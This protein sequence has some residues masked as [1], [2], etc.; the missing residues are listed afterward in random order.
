LEICNRLRSMQEPEKYLQFTQ[1]AVQLYPGEPRTLYHEALAQI[2][3]KHYDESARL[4]EQV[5]K[6]SETRAPELLDDTFHFEL[7]VSLERGGHFEEAALQFEKS[8]ELTPQDSPTK[9]AAAMN[10]LGYMWLERSEHL[11]KAEE[12]IKKANDLEPGNAAYMD[13]LGWVHFKTGRVG[14]ALGELLQAEQKLKQ[15]EPDDAEIFDHIAQAYDKSGQRAKA[16]EYWRRV[17]D[18]K[19]PDE[20][21]IQRAEKELGLKKPAPAAVEEPPA[22][23]KVR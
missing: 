20:K 22:S 6:L 7:G 8:I 14:E 2:Q 18:L 4:F 21:L 10:Y 1:R 15:P 12:L 11:D 16:E 3:N 19:P 23:S 13:S 5:A 17:L 9:A